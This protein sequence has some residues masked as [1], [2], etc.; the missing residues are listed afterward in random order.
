MRLPFSLF[1]FLGYALPGLIVTVLVILMIILPAANQQTQAEFWHIQKFIDS[2]PTPSNQQESVM[3][4]LIKYLPSNITSGIILVL[5]CYV[6]G[7]IVHGCCDFFF[8]FMSGEYIGMSDRFGVIKKY[9]EGIHSSNKLRCM[10]KYYT[11]N[12]WFEEE[13]FNCLNRGRRDP[14]EHFN[15]YSELS[16]IHI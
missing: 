7:F 8:K 5:F 9:Y 15:P 1:D 6:I 4:R 13:L 12:G 14:S 11:D 16:L 2:T 10:K 3:D